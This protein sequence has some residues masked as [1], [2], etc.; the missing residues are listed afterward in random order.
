M[1]SDETLLEAW[2]GGDSGAGET[3]LRRHFETLFGFFRGKVTD[4]GVAE[5]LVQRTLLA[6]FRGR[7]GFRS[8]AS[9]RTW[10]FTIARHE[11]FADLRRNRR[12][13]EVVAIGEVSI[14]ELSGVG[15]NTVVGQVERARLL[16]DALRRIPLDLQI[17]IEL[18]YWE[19]MSASDVATVLD[20]PMGTVKSR[21]R[22]AR[23]ALEQAMVELGGA[24]AQARDTMENLDG[25]AARVRDLAIGRDDDGRE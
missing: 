8:D 20:I 7:A 2:R 22:R 4:R 9:F 25:W 3:L 21:I 14:A 17:A 15:P 6:T 24:M 23:E 16:L 1:T 18:T 10:L 19:G 11:L 5:D 13:L 12:S